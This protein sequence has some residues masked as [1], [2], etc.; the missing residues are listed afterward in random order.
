MSY[1]RDAGALPPPSPW[2]GM[3]R[4]AAA[5]TQGVK[6]TAA[7]DLEAAHPRVGCAHVS[8]HGAPPSMVRGCGS[9]GA[10]RNCY[11]PVQQ[12]SRLPSGGAHS[13]SAPSRGCG[14]RLHARAPA[15]Q[16]LGG[17]MRVVRARAAPACGAGGRVAPRARAAHASV[18]SGAGEAKEARA[19]RVRA[20]QPGAS[21]RQVTPCPPLRAAPAAGGSGSGPPDFAE[22]LQARARGASAQNS[23][24]GRGCSSGEADCCIGPCCLRWRRPS[25][26]S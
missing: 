21:R 10:T 11:Q 19:A 7:A 2:C 26:L 4:R 8:W 24:A 23:G 14:A 16:R 25:R 15:A 6:G 22:R 18:P 12:A 20:P 13:C 9:G 1:T 3:V 17:R 5:G